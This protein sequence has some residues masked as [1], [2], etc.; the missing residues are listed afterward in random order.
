[1]S[2]LETGIDPGRVPARSRRAARGPP[3]D[4]RLPRRPAQLGLAS[5]DA[6]Q[7][8]AARAAVVEVPAGQRRPGHPTPRARAR[9]SRRCS[10]TGRWS[11]SRRST[12]PIVALVAVDDEDRAKEAAL[13]EL[14][15]ARRSAGLAAVDVA[16]FPD[17][18]TTSRATDPPRWPGRS[19]ASP[20]GSIARAGRLSCGGPDARRLHARP[21]RPRRVSETF[22]GQAIPANE[23]PERAERIRAA[24]EADGGF[25]L[26]RADRARDGSDPRRSRPGPRCASSRRPGRSSRRRGHRAGCPD[27]PTRMPSAA[28]TRA[29]APSRSGSSASP[30]RSPGRAGFWG[31]RL[32]DPARRR[33]LR[34][35]AGGRGRGPDDGR[36]RARRRRDGRLRAVPAAGPPCGP[37]DVRRLLLLQQ[38]RDRRRGHRPADRRARGRSSTST[39]T[40]ATAR[41]QIFWR[42]GDVLYVSLH[43]DPDRQYP[44][45]LGRADE[46]GEGPGAGANLNFPLDGR[47]R[48]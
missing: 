47:H 42:R 39:S 14:D 21:P 28:C 34:G 15:S 33:D 8:R 37:L 26:G 16:R 23:V 35:R 20:A 32:V 1:M 44:F 30:R 2:R 43:G 19:S 31:A 45:Y 22:M 36:S 17:T 18:A 25:E 27:A 24:L 11:A 38:R 29:S 12:L 40:T 10:S 48:R 7:E 3:L 6:D 9:P 5:W 46:T 41:E 4:R 13:A